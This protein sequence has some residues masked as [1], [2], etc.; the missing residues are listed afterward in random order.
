MKQTSRGRFLTATINDY[1]A[2]RVYHFL[3][4]YYMRGSKNQPRLMGRERSSPLI[5]IGSNNCHRK[6]KPAASFV[7][8]NI[9]WVRRPGHATS[10]NVLHW[11]GLPANP[12]D[13]PSTIPLD[14]HEHPF[15]QSGLLFMCE[16]LRAPAR[17]LVRTSLT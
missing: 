13:S 17:L 15:Y 8:P 3:T 12:Q 1:T 14:Y 10:G 16:M 9:A 11:L 7:A 6:S 2:H 5:K 4:S